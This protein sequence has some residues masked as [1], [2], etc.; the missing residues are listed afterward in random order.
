MKSVMY[1]NDTNPTTTHGYN[2]GTVHNEKE[3]ER[4]PV[5]CYNAWHGSEQIM[6]LS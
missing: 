2:Q 5:T 6:F 1:G 4:Q 3:T